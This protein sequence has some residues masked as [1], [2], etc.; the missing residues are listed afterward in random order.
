MRMYFLTG[1]IENEEGIDKVNFSS[2]A[3]IMMG[4]LLAEAT[5]N[6][7]ILLNRGE[8]Q[9]L[10][11]MDNDIFI[12]H[13]P[14]KTSAKQAKNEVK[15]I[16]KGNMKNVINPENVLLDAAINKV[17]LGSFDNSEVYEEDTV[18]WDVL[19]QLIIVLGRENLEKF[20]AYLEYLAWARHNVISD[21]DIIQ[22]IERQEKSCLIKKLSI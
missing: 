21:E 4:T 8:I 1:K 14:Q 20:C 5:A 22:L 11:K 17:S 2:N 10:Q 18:Y 12:I 15:N 6:I 13:D 3:D 7:G 19:N 16:I 9:H